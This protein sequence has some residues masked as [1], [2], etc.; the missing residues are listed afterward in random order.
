[1]NC[2]FALLIEYVAIWNRYWTV[3]ES[4]LNSPSTLNLLQACSAIKIFTQFE[5]DLL[6]EGLTKWL[7]TKWSL[8]KLILDLP[9]LQALSNVFG[10]LQAI[11]WLK[12]FLWIRN[13][14]EVQMGIKSSCGWL[15]YKG[16]YRCHD[17]ARMCSTQTSLPKISA[18]SSYIV[19][20]RL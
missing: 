2:Q 4:F 7:L 5:M 19:T 10:E 11:N 6:I 3:I 12:M 9:S 17:I 8:V 18:E 14:I 1:M 16:S 13:A 15:N 20:Y